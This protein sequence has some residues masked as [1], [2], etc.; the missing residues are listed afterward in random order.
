MTSEFPTDDVDFLTDDEALAVVDQL[1][2]HIR[3]AGLLSSAIARP[4]THAGLV[5]RTSAPGLSPAIHYS[6]SARTGHPAARPALPR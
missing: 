5:R 6:I 1:G 3:D 4:R 2:F